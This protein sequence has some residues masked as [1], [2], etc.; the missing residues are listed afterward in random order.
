MY[1]TKDKRFRP[2]LFAPP[3]EGNKVIEAAAAAASDI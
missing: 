2:I 3:K 1:C